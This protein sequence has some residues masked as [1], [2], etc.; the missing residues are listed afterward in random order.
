MKKPARP[1]AAHRTLDQVR[2]MMD[3]AEARGLARKA[4]KTKP[5]DARPARAAEVVVTVVA[6]E[7]KETQNTAA[8]GDWVVRNRCTAGR[9][10][11]IVKADE[12]QERYETAGS[13]VTREGW[14][15]FRPLGKAVRFFVVKPEH[16]EFTFT[17]PWGQSM[18]A[19]PG[20]AIVQD[21]TRPEDIYRVASAI[22]ACTYEIV[23]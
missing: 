1:I 8:A 3:D 21:P 6:G 2:Q 22:F 18:V 14:Q 16:G 13:P 11:Y 12:F 4:R 19:K 9:E 10:E 7:G 20:D 17:A 15:E 5:V 23:D